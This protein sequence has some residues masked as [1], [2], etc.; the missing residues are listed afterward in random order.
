MRS[1]PRERKIKSADVNKGKI[2]EFQFL[3][4]LRNQMIAPQ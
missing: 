1:G 4:K 2:F 3:S